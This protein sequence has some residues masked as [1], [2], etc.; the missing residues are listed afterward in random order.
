MKIHLAQIPEEGLQRSLRLELGAMP[1]LSESLGVQGGQLLADV[2]IKNREGAVEIVADLQA[3]LQAPCQ[4]CLEP[5]PVNIAETVRVAL[6]SQAS[7]DDAP[8]DAHLSEGDLELSFYEGEELDLG[9]ILEDELLLL[10]PEP[11]AEEDEQGR[12]VV[13]GKRVEDLFAQGSEADGGH[14]FAAL[15]GILNGD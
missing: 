3:T 1:R 9:H 4:R 13:C 15:K 7:Y 2:R 12:C 11:V 6:V 8:E 5:V 10:L 14:P